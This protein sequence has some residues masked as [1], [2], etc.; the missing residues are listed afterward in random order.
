M[1][2]PLIHTTPVSYR[3][4][5]DDRHND[6][7]PPIDDPRHREREDYPGD[8]LPDETE[9]V[10]PAEPVTPTEDPEPP[11]DPVGPGVSV[12]QEDET[13]A[14]DPDKPEPVPPS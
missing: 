14:P 3:L 5:G 12:E 10:P 4:T 8:E 6:Q 13:Q 9:R 2:C 7:R 1:P 11:V